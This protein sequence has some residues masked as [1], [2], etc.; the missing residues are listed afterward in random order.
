TRSA[1][2]GGYWDEIASARTSVI[3]YA[4]AIGQDD[5][6]AEATSR[7]LLAAESSLW[8]GCDGAWDRAAGGLDLARQAQQHVHSQFELV[9]F[10]AKDVTL[11]GSTGEV[12]LTLINNTGKPLTLSLHAQPDAPRASP[13]ARVIEVQPTQNFVTVPV[14][15]HN[16]ASTNLTVSLRAGDLTVAETVV[17]VRT[18]YIDRLAA[19]GMVVL[20]LIV[21]LA[22]I[23]RKVKPAI[24][25]T[26]GS[27]TDGRES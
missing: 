3:A 4:G 16:I 15:L 22:I 7:A 5:P 17:R 25:G 21:L 2:P 23:H 13:S 18:S 1:A 10:D 8:A 27:D 20:V 24:A 11:S 19:V 26:I 6:D 12:P 9:Y 14:D